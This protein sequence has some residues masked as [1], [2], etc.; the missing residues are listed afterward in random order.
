MVSFSMRRHIAV[1]LFVLMVAMIV[2]HSKN[3]DARQRAAKAAPIYRYDLRYA[4]PMSRDKSKF[5]A[6]W[7]EVHVV[8]TLQGLV[9][10]K[11]PRLYL[12]AISSSE[13]GPPIQV[14]DWWLEKL[15]APGAWLE[16]RPVED[17]PD[18][19]SLLRRFRGDV[20]GL[21]V[22]DGNVPATSNVAS[23]IAGV[24]NLLAVR[25][26]A[27]PTS[28]FNRLQKMGFKPKSWLVKRDGTSMF[29][30]K[31]VIP[32]IVQLSSGSAKNDAYRWAIRRY[33]ETGRVAD[34]TLAYYI[35][36]YPV[37]LASTRP[38]KMSINLWQC[39]LTNHDYF[40]GKRAFFFDLAPWG[41]EAASDEPSQ[42][43]GTDLATLKMMLA[44]MVRRNGG[45]K[46]IHLGGFTPWAQKYTDLAPAGGKHGA[47]P[48]E[49]ETVRITSQYNAYLDADALG[50][51]AMANASFFTHQKLPK[52]AAEKPID[53]EKYLAPDGSVI[54]HR[55]VAF[56]VGDYDAAAWMYQ[57]LPSLWS[58]PARG[59]VPL[60]W[61]FNPNL[62]MRFPAAFWYTRQ[63]RS[64]NDNFQAGDSG[65]GYVNPSQLD[66]GRASG[67]P[68]AVALW[69]A[70]NKYWYDKFG[71]GITGF[72]IDGYA[73]PMSREMLDAYARFSP[74]GVVGQK[75]EPQLR[76]ATPFLRMTSDL[77]GKPEDAANV[78]RANANGVAPSFQTFRAVLKSPSWYRDVVAAAQ[79]GDSDIVFVDP[80]TL[81]ELARRQMQ[82][83]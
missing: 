11:A 68:G 44:A 60:G 62:A 10:R 21:V 37:L 22:Y 28:L 66:E 13:G 49:W 73:P 67:L 14:D 23:T 48:T 4:G 61:A 42:K 12:R 39:T 72:V 56:Y 55:Y 29:T 34:D 35:D 15:Q 1:I 65:A 19:E 47:V 41:D 5:A 40:V 17:V 63:T 46:M 83:K 33:I 79:S 52:Y 71:I 25:Y 80:Y 20:K 70:H 74:R 38:D 57:M 24:E 69:E 30:G 6:A 8:A 76:G 36:A 51:S 18:L 78:I 53:L 75:T 32:D 26:D 81:M 50:L 58:D 77:D 9:N 64:P 16:K 7:D 2:K 82:K 31:G 45:K 3:A 54:P 59:S 27:A 43:P